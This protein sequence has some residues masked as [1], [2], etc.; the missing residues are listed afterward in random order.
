[1]TSLQP[2]PQWKAAFVN[3]QGPTPNIGDCVALALMFIAA[4]FLIGMA[5]NYLCR[6]R[7]PMLVAYVSYSVYDAQL[8][9]AYNPLW[10]SGTI[11][12]SWIEFGTYKI[13]ST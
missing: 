8:P 12:A 2:L 1:M 9:P 11:V 5:T 6:Q 4:P 7:R 13:N 10:Y 3:P